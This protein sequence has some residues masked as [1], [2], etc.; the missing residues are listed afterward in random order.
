M[1]RTGSDEE[2]TDRGY[3]IL[4]PVAD[5][6]ELARSF[7]FLNRLFNHLARILFMYGEGMKRKPAINKQCEHAIDRAGMPFCETSSP[8]SIH[9]GDRAARHGAG[10]VSQEYALGTYVY[11][12]E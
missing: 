8:G 4:G 6:D 1:V 5:F 10:K 12:G 3:H 2:P 7:I 11:R 9:E